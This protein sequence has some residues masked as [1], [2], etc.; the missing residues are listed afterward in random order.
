[1][2]IRQLLRVDF[3]SNMSILGSQGH[4]L[5][6]G[7]KFPFSVDLSHWPEWL[8]SIDSFILKFKRMICMYMWIQSD[9]L[10]CANTVKWLTGAQQ[11]IFWPEVVLQV[12]NT[13]RWPL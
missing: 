13:Y 8:F 5:K 6:L 11:R 7:T 9:I 2:V 1:M 4:V 12:K 3:L 10:I